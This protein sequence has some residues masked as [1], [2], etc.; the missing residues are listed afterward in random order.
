V[1]AQLETVTGRVVRS[2]MTI[3]SRR[4][5]ATEVQ[6][7]MAISLEPSGVM[8]S[9][10]TLTVPARGPVK[11]RLTSPDSAPVTGS[12]AARAV[13]ATPSAVLKVPPM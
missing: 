6:L 10:S 5:P 1:V 7:P 2:S 12:T 8:S 3:W 9:L 4:R 13:R 11:A